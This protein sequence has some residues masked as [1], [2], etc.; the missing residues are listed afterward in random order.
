MKRLKMLICALAPRL[1]LADDGFMGKVKIVT[2]HSPL[3]SLTAFFGNHGSGK[4][5]SPDLP[6]G[7]QARVETCFPAVLDRRLIP[8]GT[9][10]PRV[11]S[12]ILGPAT[13][14]FKGLVIWLTFFY[15]FIKKKYPL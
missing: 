13:N 9:E 6:L 2:P 14:D 11:P 15:S 10:N 12:S 3:S 7:G 5:D 4:V 1:D 8:R